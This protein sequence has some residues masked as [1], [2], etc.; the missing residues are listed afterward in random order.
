MN[1]SRRS[2]LWSAEGSDTIEFAASS[3]FFMF[4]AFATVEYGVLFSER[5]A[6]TSLAREGASL[7]SRNITTNGNIMSMLASTDGTLGLKN[8]PEK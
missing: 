8:H 6:V 7:A 1:Q 2:L 3:V 4:M 5:T